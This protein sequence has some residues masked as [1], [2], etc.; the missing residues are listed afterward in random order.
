MFVYV[1]STFFFFFCYCHCPLKQLP[2]RLVNL[3]SECV[4]LFLQKA[5]R[6]GNL[7]AKKKIEI[8]KSL[9]SSE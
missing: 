5:L 6:L 8:V 2:R 1:S 9:C 3:F 7:L 4:L